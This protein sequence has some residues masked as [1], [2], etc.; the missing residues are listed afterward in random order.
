M[1]K[2]VVTKPHHWIGTGFTPSGFDLET[3]CI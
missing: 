3:N 1:A 2:S